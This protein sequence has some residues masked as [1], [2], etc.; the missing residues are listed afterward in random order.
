MELLHIVGKRRDCTILVTLHQPSDAILGYLNKIVVMMQ[1]EVVFDEYTEVVQ[2]ALAMDKY[3]TR[4]LS[5]FV[6]GVVKDGI[7]S[8]TMELHLI[9]SREQWSG[10][11]AL[12]DDETSKGTSTMAIPTEHEKRHPLAQV[13]PLGRRFRL[14][15][16]FNYADLVTL[17]VCFSILAFSLGFDADAPVNIYMGC[18]V[19]FLV[20]ILLFQHHLHLSWDMWRT[21]RWELDDRRIFV[22][23]FQIASVAFSLSM[24]LI[25]TVSSLALVY[26]IL[27]WDWASFPN[28]TLF[29]V[30]FL[31]VIMTFGRSLILAC[32]GNYTIFMRVYLICIFLF[33]VFGG[34]MS[35]PDQAPESAK[36]LFGLSF[37]FWG[38]SAIVTSQ[39]EHNGRI[40]EQDA[41]L[42]FASCVVFDGNFLSAQ[43]GFWPFSN[44]D[45]ALKV[46]SCIYVT[47]LTLEYVL[48]RYRRAQFLDPSSLKQ[49]D[50]QPK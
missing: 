16:G 41:C 14:N 37:A 23:S 7:V 40:G 30:L 26:A 25:A 6:H 43:S 17:P 38:F 34:F 27:G 15:Y 21:H 49:L 42:S 50:K 44:T 33:V 4:R 31:V 32:N 2:S 24:P 10:A 13:M 11:T 29:G 28:Q 20:P 19:M 36:W 5:E 18:V 47:F 35:T 3:R 39:F 45:R 48:L 22:S 1:G 8:Q 12:G 9:Q 46:L